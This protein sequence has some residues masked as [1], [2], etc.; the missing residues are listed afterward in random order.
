MDSYLSC[1]GALSRVKRETM[2][3]YLVK[4]FLREVSLG[5]SAQDTAATLHS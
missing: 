4:L 5:V 3:E 1:S 2:S